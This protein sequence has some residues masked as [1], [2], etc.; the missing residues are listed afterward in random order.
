MKNMYLYEKIVYFITKKILDYLNF[1]I[2]SESYVKTRDSI[3][4]ATNT[5]WLL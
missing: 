2:K 5:A 4:R 1:I 3:S